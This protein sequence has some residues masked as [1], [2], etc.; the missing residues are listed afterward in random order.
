M[1]GLRIICTAKIANT[2]VGHIDHAMAY[3]SGFKRLG[4][5]VYLME[6]V[7]PGCCVNS[8]NHEVSFEQWGG[9]LHFEAVA[10]AYGIWPRCCLIY[11]QGVATYGMSFSEAVKLANA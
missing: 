1:N 7:G 6:H 8:N 5:E 11:K 10:R 9:R 4:H 2:T 3:A